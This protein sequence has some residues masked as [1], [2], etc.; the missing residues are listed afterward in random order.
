M[1]G[2]AKNPQVKGVEGV[3]KTYRETTPLLDMWGPTTFKHFLRVI[4]TQLDAIHA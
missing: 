2:D 3:L 4:N 1:N